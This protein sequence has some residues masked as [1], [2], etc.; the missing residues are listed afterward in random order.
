MAEQTFVMYCPRCDRQYMSTKSSGDVLEI[1]K[2]HVTEQHPDHDP[3]WAED[4][5]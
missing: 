2:K 3:N 4:G 1:V 5:V